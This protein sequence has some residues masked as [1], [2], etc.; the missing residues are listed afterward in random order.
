M[1]WVGLLLVALVGMVLLW[2]PI[3]LIAT[4]FSG[5]WELANRYPRRRPSMGARRGLGTVAFSPVFQYKR[6]VNFVIDDDHLHLSLPPILGIFHAPM[7]IPWPVI[8]FPTGAKRIAGMTL[9]KVENRRILVSRAMAERELQVRRALE[10][11]D[12]ED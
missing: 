10:V 8:E 11:L 3:M 12:D 5:W 6:C 2:M 9:I 1:T 4:L 7:S